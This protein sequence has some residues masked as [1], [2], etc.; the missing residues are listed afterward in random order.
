MLELL[1]GTTARGAWPQARRA[2]EEAASQLG[3]RYP[4]VAKL[5]EEHGE[6]ILAVYQLPPA[7]GKRLRSTN[8]LERLSQK[9]KRR[10]RVVRI[11]PDE[12]ACLRLVCAGDG[13]QCGVDGKA[14]PQN[15]RDQSR[16]GGDRRVRLSC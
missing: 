2:V 5:L 10:T 7:H 13:N 11:F 12:T 16:G 1:K 15:G 14:L 4:R 8:L 9:I 6:E 3:P